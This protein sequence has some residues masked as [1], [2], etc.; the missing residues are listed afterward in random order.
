MSNQS[1]RRGQKTGGGLY[2]PP[3]GLMYNEF[4]GEL[5]PPKDRTFTE[6]HVR[7]GERNG[8]YLDWSITLYAR[9]GS[10][11]EFRRRGEPLERRTLE[12]VD[13]S[14]SA[15]R[16]HVYVPYEPDRPPT[17]TVVTELHS[18]DTTKVDRAYQV[19]MNGLAAGW[20]QKH[21]GAFGAPA[22]RHTTATIGFVEKIRDP[23]LVSG[24]LS[25]VRNTVICTETDL[26]DGVISERAGHYFPSAKSTAAV[27][28]SSGRMQF[29][30]ATPGE[31]LTPGQ[32]EETT[33]SQELNGTPVARGAVTMGMMVD[34]IYSTDWTTEV[35]E[36]LGG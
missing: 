17:V 27:L 14:K 13:V 33:A 25:W 15:V 20:A 4:V 12:V 31:Q 34:S 7:Y 19:A 23:Q 9:N 24:N 16:R 29:I 26:V 35:D 28:R 30:V 22:D 32:A 1:Q 3:I 6:V 36:F 2:R 11:E 10:A 5:W 21:G 8:L 18:G